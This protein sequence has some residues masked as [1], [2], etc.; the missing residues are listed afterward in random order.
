MRIIRHLLSH[1]ILLVFLI[2]LG[3]AYHYRAK[4]FSEE[5]VSRIDTT[6]NKTMAFLNI[7]LNKD[8]ESKP[9]E[10]ASTES[11]SAIESTS[12]SET[13]EPATE[14]SLATEETETSVV[15]TDTETPADATMEPQAETPA[16]V[17]A[18]AP[19][20]EPTV[21]PGETTELP[22]EVASQDSAEQ[23]TEATEQAET[24]EPLPTVT[25][26][27]ETAT[28]TEPAGSV[29][30]DQEVASAEPETTTQPEQ[31]AVSSDKQAVVKSHAQLIN[32]ARMAFQAGNPDQ[33]VS[34]YQE[35]AELNPD[36]P[37]VYG[38]LGNV[39]YAQGKWKQAGQAYYE[40]ATRLLQHGQTGQ[41]HY[42]YMVIQGLD[43]ES[44]EKLR[45]QIG[46]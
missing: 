12:Q 4:L 39:Y 20:Q 17:E 34:L 45:G 21:T 1:A 41:V 31:A 36:D 2:A 25:P 13:A 7:A 6:V 32:E 26:E 37:N 44:A 3:F 28:S 46:G 40:A 8:D 5:I 33:A 15:S 29:S 43:Q 10:V 24:Q 27:A 19:E 18:S 9:Q 23:V 14:S 11:G 16:A 22:T 42:L 38:E 30:T 35:L